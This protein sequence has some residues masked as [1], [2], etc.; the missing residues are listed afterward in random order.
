MPL[1]VNENNC[2]KYVALDDMDLRELGRGHFV[3]VRACTGL[4]EKDGDE[5]IGKLGG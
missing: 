5:A 1:Q 4:T 2:S 3:H